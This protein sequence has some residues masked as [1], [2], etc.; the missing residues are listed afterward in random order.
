M[1]I[2]VAVK[3]NDG[4]VLASDSTVVIRGS[5]AG[6]PSSVLKTYDHGRKLADIKDYPIGTLT[7]GI[8]TIGSRTIES[9]ISEYEFTLP[10]ATHPEARGFKVRDI[11]ENLKTFLRQRYETEQGPLVPQA[12]S[13]M[14][15]LGILVSG[16]SDG[17]Y[18]PEQYLFDFP[19]MPE[20]QPRHP[21]KANGEPEF[22]VDWFGQNDTITRLIKGAD[23]RLA[24]ALAERLK[25]PSEEIWRLLSQFEYRVALEGMPLQDAIDLAVY[26]VETTIGRHR[27][28]MG[29][30]FC[31]GEIDVAVITPQ[32][33]T[34]V[35]RKVWHAGRPRKSYGS[36]EGCSSQM[37]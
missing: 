22:G 18:F 25:M 2:A 20:L 10:S 4:L 37:V 8:S 24:V 33:F 35:S 16:Y 21:N 11:A 12:A 28:V 36:D 26:L 32:G 23:P 27:F 30:P 17:A 29:A 15:S 7:W 6:Q 1:S 31:G 3:V 9:L 14:P 13:R 5:S 19:M 34:W